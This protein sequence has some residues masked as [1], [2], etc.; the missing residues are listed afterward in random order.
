MKL[1]QAVWWECS[2][3]RWACDYKT[4]AEII[5]WVKGPCCCDNV[6]VYY[7]FTADASVW[8][9]GHINP[10]VTLGLVLGRRITVNR[11]LVYVVAQMLGSL[12][13]AGLVKALQEVPFDELNGGTNFVN[14]A[15]SNSTGLAAEIVGTFVLVYVVYTATD[16]KR[17]A[18]DSYVPVSEPTFTLA[19]DQICRSALAGWPGPARAHCV[20]S[21]M[22][23]KPELEGRVQPER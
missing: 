10:A 19:C 4:K 1:T 3:Y 22:H 6:S 9:G 5:I 8:T 14:P 12:C 2:L 23:G 18:R 20:K 16:A 15:F 17:R 13:G 21:I 7:I 11:A